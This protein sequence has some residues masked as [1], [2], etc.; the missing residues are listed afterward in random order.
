[1]RSAVSVPET[2]NGRSRY[3]PIREND[4]ALS[5]QSMKSGYDVP[6]PHPAQS[7]VALHSW[8][9]TSRSGSTNGSGL[10]RDRVDDAEHRDVRADAERE[11]R[12]RDERE[13]LRLREAANREAEGPSISASMRASSWKPGCGEQS[14]LASERVRSEKTAVVR[15]SGRRGDP[16]CV[17]ARRPPQSHAIR[18]PTFSCAALFDDAAVEEVDRAVG[19]RGVAR[20][21]R[22]H[23]DRRAAAVQLAKQLHHRFAVRRIE[24]TRRFVGEEDERIAGDRAGDGDALLLTAGELRRIVLHAVAHAHALERV[25]ARAACARPPTCRD[26]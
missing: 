7:F 23:A 6:T 24:V 4:R 20:I 17:R 2:A 16:M 9:S 21:V 19:V 15:G 14:A 18:S 3:A 5:R 22:D 25:R 8:R 12:E 13:E 11:R 10:K 26:T 1:M